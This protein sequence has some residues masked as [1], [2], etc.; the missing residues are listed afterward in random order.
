VL[1]CTKAAAVN[2][3]DTTT[4]FFSRNSSESMTCRKYELQGVKESMCG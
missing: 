1:H 4:T 2:H 3:T